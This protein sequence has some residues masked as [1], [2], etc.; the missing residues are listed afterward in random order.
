ME[1][2]TSDGILTSEDA[3]RTHDLC[4]TMRYLPGIDR[5]QSLSVTRATTSVSVMTVWR[6]VN[7]KF[8]MPLHSNVAASLRRDEPFW[9]AVR[10]MQTTSTT[11]ARA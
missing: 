4:T 5:E 9:G 10:M 3:V 2:G 7:A 6:R 8:Y 1:P 11:K